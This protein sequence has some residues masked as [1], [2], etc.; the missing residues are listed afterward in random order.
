MEGLKSCPGCNW[1]FNTSWGEQQKTLAFLS[2]QGGKKYVENAT[3]PAQPHPALPRARASCLP[4]MKA[5]L[6]FPAGPGR[7][8]ICQESELCQP[9]C[10][11]LCRN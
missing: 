11:L 10:G 9:H 8:R 6:F 4:G 7:P 1:N 3:V 5:V 2:P